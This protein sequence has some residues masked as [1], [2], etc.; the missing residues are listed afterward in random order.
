MY[1][2]SSWQEDNNLR[3]DLSKYVQQLFKREEII[4]FV[5]RDYGCYS[6]SEPR[7]K[8]SFFDIFYIDTSVTVDDVKEAV[9]TDL[10]GP[11]QLLG[12]RAMQQKVRLEHGLNVPRALIHTYE[13]DPEGLGSRRLGPKNKKTKGHFTTKGPNFVHSLDGHDKLMGFQNSRNLRLY[14][15]SQQETTV[16]ESVGHKFQPSYCWSLAHLDYLFQ[17]KFIASYLH[18]DKGTETGLLATMHAFLRCHHGDLDDP[19][20]SVIYGPSTSNQVQSCHLICNSQGPVI[21][22]ADQSIQRITCTE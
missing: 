4:N 18:M 14:R 10:S 17:N 12:Y 9:K 21:Q 13:L 1:S 20:D 6:Y 19:C 16:G 11:G 2:N 15:H 22:R 5:L 7:Q 8:A 3:E